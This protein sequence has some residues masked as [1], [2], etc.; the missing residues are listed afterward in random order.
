MKKTKEKTTLL[1]VPLEHRVGR[2]GAGWKHLGGS[3]YEKDEVRVH[4][5]GE[6]CRLKNGVF[7]SG[8]HWP[9]SRNLDRAI[10]V[11]GGN[12]KRGTMAWANMLMM[13]NV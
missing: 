2:P 5:S 3:V 1:V 9:M 8:N 12:K 4:V 6:L 11:N 10:R 13:P 7:V